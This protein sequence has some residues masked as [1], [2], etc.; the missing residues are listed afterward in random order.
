MTLCMLFFCLKYILYIFFYCTIKTKII[1][2]IMPKESN[3]LPPKR[4]LAVF[5][6]NY[7][8]LRIRCD[9]NK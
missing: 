8:Q 9:N 5:A 2:I 7:T 6:H 1:S 4:E 3:F